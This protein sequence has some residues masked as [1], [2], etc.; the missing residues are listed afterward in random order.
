MRYSV[1]EDK[2]N[3]LECFL[4]L[5]SCIICVG[6]E[7]LLLN[8]ITF[9]NIIIDTLWILLQCAIA[10]SP[11]LFVRLIKRIF[12]KFLLKLCGIKNL[13]GTYEVEIESTYKKRP[14]S[15][16]ILKIQQDLDT[17]KIYF[18]AD[19]SKSY[20]INASIENTNLYPTLYY[21]YYNEGNGSDN[22]NKT[23]IGTAVLTFIENKV[24]GYYYNNGKDRQTH[25]TIRSLE[26]QEQ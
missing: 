4:Y 8:K 14:T 22:K 9:P 15:H 5:T 26:K 25:G 13:S 6:L 2:R 18:I 3:I 19:K 16:A 17:I 23:H 1:T 7:V 11:F 12:G 20:A 24:D 10:I 21:T